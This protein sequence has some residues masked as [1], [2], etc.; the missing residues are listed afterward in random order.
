M[1]TFS[2]KPSDITR[3]WLV[4]D[5]QG[6]TLGRLATAVAK[7]LK[8]KH[9]PEYTPN[10][11]TGDYIIIVNADKIVVTGKKQDDKIYY[12]HTGYIGGLKSIPYKKLAAYQPEKII[13]K[14][15]KGMLPNN[16]LGRKMYKKLKIYASKDHP[17]HA[18]QP[19]LINI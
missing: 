18:Q 7:R 3:E 11:D 15:V 1:K 4:V 6:Q 19:T 12:H 10:Q 5:A 16:P 2:A 13:E 14:A 8:G 17:H 9:K